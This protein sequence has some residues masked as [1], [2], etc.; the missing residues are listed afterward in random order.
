MIKKKKLYYFNLQINFETN[1]YLKFSDLLYLL[2]KF[3]I[4]FNL[5]YIINYL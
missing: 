5:I 4:Y 1:N 2:N 3:L